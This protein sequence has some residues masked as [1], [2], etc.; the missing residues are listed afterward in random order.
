M[1]EGSVR[2][3]DKR[4][5]ITAQLIDTTTG[6]HLWAE[7]YD[8]E[9]KDIFTLQDE[10][11]QQ[12]V[13]AL[14]IKFTQIEQ[15]RALRKDTANLN[16]FDYNLQ[17][18]WY[19]QRFTKEDN[20]QA[21]RMF[22]K[23]IELEPKFA[24]AYAGLGLTYH[25]QWSRL[26]SQDPRSLDRAFELAKKA[27]SLNDSLSS[28]Y[29]LLG[30]VYLWRKQLTQAI[31][32]QERAIALNPN[33]A[34]GYADL[35]EILV[36]MGR[37][38]KALVSVQKAMRLNPH[39]PVNYLFIL[40]F[41]YS[42]MEQYEEAMSALKKVLTRSPDH[43]GAH[44]MLAIIYDEMGREEEAR[45]QVAEALRINPQLSMELLEQIIPFKDM[46]IFERMGENLRKSGLK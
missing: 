45:A 3:A 20:E 22:E 38:Q 40:G 17:G 29:T 35:A 5:R 18:W 26:W 33:N 7:R 8:R 2:K 11:T 31:A 41:A 16:A 9:L 4:V 28:A 46:A 15:E 43:L 25:E 37:P 6:G 14:D 32:E 19:Y 24:S 10:I 30:H 23:T 21:R 36:W 44:L 39:Y 27:I 42:T 1:L 34:N 13:S 12:I